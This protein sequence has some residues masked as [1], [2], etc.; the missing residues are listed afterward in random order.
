MNVLTR[1]ECPGLCLSMS[2][3]L[4]V[5]SLWSWYS[6]CGTH[7][8]KS[9]VIM[10]LITKFIVPGVTVFLWKLAGFCPSHY[11]Q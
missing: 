9:Y 1:T 8:I 5:H 10:M 3:C 6:P 7:R 11:W 4:V 2:L